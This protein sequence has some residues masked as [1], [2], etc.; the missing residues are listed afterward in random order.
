[1]GKD[2]V[3][4]VSACRTAIGSFNGQYSRIPA[5]VLG[6]TVIKDCLE[7]AK[8]TPNDVSEVIMGHVLTAG[9][10]QNPA[11]QSSLG[12]G[13]PIEVPAYTVNIL[14]GSG[15]KTVYLG[16]QAIRNGDAS[17]VVCGGQEN[18]TLAQHSA[19]L[20]SGVK[21]G[22]LEL[23]DTLMVDGLTDVFTN[24]V[25]GQTAEHL[26]RKYNVS[27]EE[28]DRYACN[29]QA[30]A[31]K[32]LA[33]N[34]FANELV[35]VVEPKKGT[36]YLKDEFVKS[37]ITFEKLS[38]LPT[39]FEKDPKKNPTVTAGNS[40]GINDGAAAV[41]VCS[42]AQMQA[43]NLVP[44]A[45]IVAF[46]QSGL[47]P[48][49]M[50]LGP[51]NSVKEVLKKANWNKDEVDLYEI[52]EAFASQSLIVLQ[53]LGLDQSKVNVTGGA[54]ALGHPLGASGARVLVTLIYN[55][56]RLGLQKGIASLC[57]GGG[58]GIAIAIERVK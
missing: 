34:Y 49:E 18:M 43:K 17:I 40:S 52:N 27:R 45:K 8:I 29:S 48:I 57:I 11:R 10:G 32:A 4:I 14:C 20:R 22:G 42:E 33:E 7:R 55:L 26:A 30:K 56:Q 6:T 31:A 38:Q 41:I 19:L 50:G 15:L 23:K 35:P 3:Y 36:I 12:A 58:M 37:D 47:E 28:Q 13:I 16:Y 9:Q 5:T 46:A 2:D 53:Q 24:L 21:L 25:M 51:V 44:L 54:I 39:A 1:M